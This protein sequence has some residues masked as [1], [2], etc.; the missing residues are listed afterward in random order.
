MPH[1][2]KH[3]AGNFLRQALSVL[4]SAALLAYVLSQA[5]FGELLDTLRAVS[6]GLL[7][8]SGALLVI[9][10][11]L[12]AMKC[13][14]LKRSMPVLGTVMSY[15]KLRFFALLPGGN[16][17]GEA[18]RLMALRDMTDG[19]E[20][21][22]LMIIDKQTQM[23][24][25]QALCLI[26]LGFASVPVHWVFFF[27]SG[28]TLAWALLAPGTLLFS[29]VRRLALRL[30]KWVSRFGWGHVVAEEIERLCGACAE[31]STHP[32]TV[33][34]HLLL[35]LSGDLLNIAAQM[36]IAYALGFSISPIDWLWLNG[37]VNIAM[38]L[39]FSV[40]GIGLREGAMVTM[41]GLFG[42]DASIAML[43]PLTIS[44]LTLIKGMAEGVVQMAVGRQK[45]KI[46]TKP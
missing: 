2:K 21:A 10:D 44:A 31:L 43:L 34:S 17:T 30:G 24:P 38:C 27:L 46:V 26:G 42:V 12:M 18:A 6:P 16:V 5:D 36:L 40:G 29:P 20:A 8:L 28:F 14:V 33:A 23:I 45:K 39:P 7:C 3:R 11:L 9:V 19:Y 25:Q 32:G 41:L 1:V 22:T 37:I 15:F 35:G 13:W 4:V